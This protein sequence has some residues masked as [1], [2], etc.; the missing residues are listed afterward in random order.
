M[1]PRLIL[2]RVPLL[3]Q[4]I[5]LGVLLGLIQ[6]LLFFLGLSRF[7]MFVA[8]NCRLYQGW[9]STLGSRSWQVSSQRTVKK[10]RQR[11]QEPVLSPDLQALL[12]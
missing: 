6:L 4:H 10:E 8:A 9:F 1:Q 2:S 3:L 5:G 12:S 7:G 11:E